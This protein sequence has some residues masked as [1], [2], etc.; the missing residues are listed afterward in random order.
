MENGTGM[1]ERLQKEKKKR[2]ETVLHGVLCTF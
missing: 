2:E 1:K